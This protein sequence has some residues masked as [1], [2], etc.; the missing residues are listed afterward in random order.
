MPLNDYTDIIANSQNLTDSMNAGGSYFQD[1]T[2]NIPQGSIWNALNNI[3]GKDSTSPEH[4]E[5]LNEYNNNPFVR[6]QG[7]LQSMFAKYNSNDPNDQGVFSSGQP[8][9]GGRFKDNQET[10]PFANLSYQDQLKLLQEHLSPGRGMNPNQRISTDLG[11]LQG[12]G[13]YSRKDLTSYLSNTPIVENGLT[14]LDQGRLNSLFNSGFWSGNTD[15][16]KDNTFGTYLKNNHNWGFDSLVDSATDYKRKLTEAQDKE[17]KFFRA[18]GVG[19]VL[20]VVGSAFRAPGIGTAISSLYKGEGL[21]T[22]MRKGAKAYITSNL[23]SAA[24]DNLG[25]LGDSGGGAGGEASGGVTYNGEGMDNTGF[26]WDNASGVN[27]GGGLYDASSGWGTMPEMSQMPSYSMGDYSGGGVQPF[28]Q[29]SSFGD[30]WNK[31]KNS[32]IVQNYLKPGAQWAQQNAPLVK[33]GLGYLY[34]Q[35]QS[36]KAL[37]N[38]QQQYD[39]INRSVAGLRDLYAPNSPYALQ[40]QKEMDARD[41]ASGRR[42][43]YGQRSVELAAKLADQQTKAGGTMANAYTGMSQLSN[44]M[45]QLRSAPKQMLMSSLS[46]PRTLQSLYNL[47]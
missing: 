15:A 14:G 41:A 47:F 22:A 12:I 11:G 10:N 5:W 6:D 25:A 3:Y 42:S 32:D 9:I 44:Y 7:L 26:N 40:M 30:A 17:D 20:N 13:G 31:I 38:A 18:D 24:G 36:K 8:G 21:N 35:Q 34:T 33:A 4:Q 16:G 46:D 28:D 1:I 2:G 39:N 27:A 43:Q 37:A 45:D 29:S 19:G 23:S